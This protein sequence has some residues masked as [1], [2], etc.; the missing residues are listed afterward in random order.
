MR[1]TRSVGLAAIVLVVLIAASVGSNGAVAQSAPSAYYGP[2]V[3][4]D[5]TALPDGTTIVAVVD[6]TV[7]DRIT[8]SGG[9]YGG[10]AP[11]DE[12][13]R[14]SQT[15]QTV[16]F[17]VEAD[18]GTRIEA[19][20]TDSDPTAGAEEFPLAFPD[21]VTS[22]GSNFE[23]TALDPG[24]TTVFEDETVT[25]TATV[26]NQV[27]QGTET[28]A[29]RIDGAERATRTVTLDNDESRTV[30]FAVDAASLATGEH[31]YA[32]TTENDEQTASLTVRSRSPYFAVSGLSPEETTVGQAERFDVSG[33][34]T[35]D[36]SARGTQTVALTVDGNAIEETTVT[37]APDESQTV[38]F[39][40]VNATR[41]GSGA[42]THAVETT[43][44]SQR[45]SLTVEGTA[46]ATFAVTD[47]DPE[48]TTVAPG[49]SVDLTATVANT[50]TQAGSQQVRLRV[51]GDQYVSRSLSLAGGERQT[52]TITLG[53]EG[54]STGDHA[55][56]FVTDDDEEGGTVTLS[57]AATPTPTPT[58]TSTAAG[59]TPATTPGEESADPTPTAT[60]D[61]AATAATDTA[62]DPTGTEA[63][64]ITV[65]TTTQQPE[66]TPTP[67]DEGGGG[68]P[69]GLVQTITLGLGA[70]IV[71]V[72]GVLKA[73]AIYLG[74]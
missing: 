69:M 62:T 4:D 3:T 71:V 24:D 60:S 43:N 18:D 45:G 12:K 48:S 63:A 58:P 61:T 72:Y 64:T 10:G 57:E 51:D 37:L 50:G 42:H 31:T 56:S 20:R 67:T 21:G 23:V 65:A 25:V 11:L 36:G 6:G 55:Y 7:R 40:D 74:Y 68:L 73:L 70:V 14:V 54:R 15:N 47:L 35:N 32:V 9:T 59:S 49:T 1:D 22:S 33:T 27:Q 19:N 39:S 5:G 38:T 46:P 53:T 66:R 16:R 17:Y 13:L 52:V 26:T 30:A 28:V 29:L 44:D 41:I 34:V 2:A 8:V